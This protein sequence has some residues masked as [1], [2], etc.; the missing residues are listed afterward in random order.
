[1]APLRE[2]EAKL[3]VPAKPRKESKSVLV[4]DLSFP[5]FGTPMGGGGE[6]TQ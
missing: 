1:M 2:H 3:S 6:G 4:P 5:T